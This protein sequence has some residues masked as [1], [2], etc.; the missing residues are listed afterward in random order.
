M[1]DIFT[2]ADMMTLESKIRK[3]GFVYELVER[4]DRV[5]I[6]AQYIEDEII[7]YEVFIIR[8]RKESVRKVGDKTFTY[9]GGEKFPCNEDF[10]Y[11]AYTCRTLERARSRFAELDLRLEMTKRGIELN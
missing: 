4:N 5:A 9:S 10:G 8:N 11:T 1:K 7:A 3:N 6:Y 2:F